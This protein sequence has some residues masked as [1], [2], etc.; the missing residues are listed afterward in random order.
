MFPLSKWWYRL[1]R[2]NLTVDSYDEEGYIG[3]DVEG[4]KEG[5]QE[6]GRLWLLLHNNVSEKV[7]KE[8]EGREEQKTRH[9]IHE[10]KQPVIPSLILDSQNDYWTQSSN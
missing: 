3:N 10:D 5:P 2:K 1:E 6:I 4:V 9:L 8:R 7:D